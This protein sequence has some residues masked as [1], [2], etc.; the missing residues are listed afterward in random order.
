MSDF[1]LSNIKKLQQ[2]KISNPE[3][4][5]R[6]LL[7]YS[8]NIKNEII[9]SNF[10]IN[11]INIEK[12]NL[13]LNRRLANEPISKIIN[14]KSFWKDDFYVN[15]FVLDPRPETEGVIEEILNIVKD[16]KKKK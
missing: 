4:D 11:Q 8:K 6:I 1:I 14:N 10:N 3:I 16:K 2:K 12:F 13:L 15:K 5:L 7:N 9:L